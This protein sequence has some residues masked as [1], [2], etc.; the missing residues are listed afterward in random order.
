MSLRSWALLTI[1]VV[2]AIGIVVGVGHG[3]RRA[4]HQ[5]V[6]AKQVPAPAQAA[7]P[8]ATKP[9]AAPTLS[10]VA[11]GHLPAPVMDPAAA[12]LP[13]RRVLLAGGLDSA[14]VSVGN[15][16]VNGRAAGQVTPAFHDAAAAAGGYV[17]GGG[18]PSRDA[19]LHVSSSGRATQV[20]RLPQPA[21]DVGAAALGGTYYVVGGYTGTTPLRSIVAWRPGAKARVVAH[22]PIALRYAAVA[23]VGNQIVIAGGTS[24]VTASRAIYAFDPA[25]SAVRQIGTLP[26]PLTHAAAATLGGYV[27]V[28]GGRGADLTSQTRR[29]LSIDPRTGAVRNA[30]VLPRAI[31][32]TGA[33]AAAGAIV[34]SGGRDGAGQVRSEVLRLEPR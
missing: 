11:A 24:G 22:L 9:P 20:G 16:L 2:A 27:Y 4:I 12:L 14:D 7:A 19:I 18:E 10:A 17:F 28:V 25:R 15:V 29:V 6:S 31:S 21:S 8:A 23:T 32:D 26:R 33:V 34:V 3:A 13:D 1:S 5:P 30:G